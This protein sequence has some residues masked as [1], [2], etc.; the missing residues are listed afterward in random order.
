M[1]I[2]EAVVI[3]RPL[4]E[5]WAAFDNPETLKRWQPTLESF[6]HMSGEPGQPGAQSRLVY[7]E[8]KRTIEMTETLLERGEGYLS[9][10][11]LVGGSVSPTVNRVD[12]VFE[13]LDSS[14]RWRM[15]SEFRFSGI[16][17]FVMPLMKAMFAKRIRDDMRRFKEVVEA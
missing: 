7:V 2:T 5:V 8:G 9:G 4:E 10:E 13:R 6:E 16:E 3:D 17:R 14:T 12:N 15:V 11:Y 1:R